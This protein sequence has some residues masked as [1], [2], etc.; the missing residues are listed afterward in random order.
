MIRFI[1]DIGNNFTFPIGIDSPEEV[2]KLLE[3]MKIDLIM[4]ELCNKSVEDVV[5]KLLDLK[6]VEQTDIL[7]I[8]AKLFNEASISNQKCQVKFGELT[9]KLIHVLP[10]LLTRNKFDS[11]KLKPREI[12]AGNFEREFWKVVKN[13]TPIMHDDVNKDRG[14]TT[15]MAHLYNIDMIQDDRLFLLLLMLTSQQKRHKYIKLLMKL[16]EPRVLQKISMHGARNQAAVQLHKF[17][18]ENNMLGDMKD[19]KGDH[20]EED[21]D[22]DFDASNSDDDSSAS[23]NDSDTEMPSTSKSIKKTKKSPKK[24]KKDRKSSDSSTTVDS[25]DIVRLFKDHLTNLQA[26]KQSNFDIQLF[27]SCNDDEK[28]QCAQNLLDAALKDTNGTKIYADIVLSIVQLSIPTRISKRNFNLFL[29]EAFEDKMKILSSQ[30]EGGNVD[31]DFLRGT[32]QF[33]AHLYVVDG[34]KISV[35]NNWLE[36]TKALAVDKEQALKILLDVHDIFHESMQ[37]RDV[38]AYRNFMGFLKDIHSKQPLPDSFLQVY[39][40]HLTEDFTDIKPVVKAVTKEKN[41]AGGTNAPVKQVPPQPTSSPYHTCKKFQEYLTAIISDPTISF[42]NYKMVDTSTEA[43]QGCASI[44]LDNCLIKMETTGIYCQSLT[45]EILPSLSSENQEKFKK[46]IKYCIYTEMATIANLEKY[47]ASN[48]LRAS[49]LTCCLCEFYKLY[50][51]DKDL[52]DAWLERLHLSDRGYYSESKREFDTALLFT[53]TFMGRKEKPKNLRDRTQRLKMKKSKYLDEMIIDTDATFKVNEMKKFT[54]IVLN[55]QN[56]TMDDVKTAFYS[57]E[58]ENDK[59]FKKFLDGFHELCLKCP[60]PSASAAIAKFLCIELKSFEFREKISDLICA[61]FRT[62]LLS[63]KNDWDDAENDVDRIVLVAAEFYNY[64]VISCLNYMNSLEK[65]AKNMTATKPIFIFHISLYSTALKLIHTGDGSDLQYIYQYIKSKPKSGQLAS[66]Y[67]Q[68]IDHYTAVFE[69]SSATVR[70]SQKKLTFAIILDNLNEI[71]FDNSVKYLEQLDVFNNKSNSGIFNKKVLSDM[72]KVNIYVR[73]ASEIS[74]FKYDFK[75]FLQGSLVVDFGNILNVPSGIDR[76]EKIKPLKE[77]DIPA[78][79]LIL[80]FVIEMYSQRF[81]NT[82]YIDLLL[83]FLSQDV[84]MNRLKC[85][86]YYLKFIGARIERERLCSLEECFQRIKQSLKSGHCKVLFDRIEKLSKN[87]WKFDCDEDER[88]YMLAMG[89]DWKYN[90][91]KVDADVQQSKTLKGKVQ[92]VGIK[93]EDKKIEK[94]NSG[95]SVENVGKGDHVQKGSTSSNVDQTASSSSIKDHKG[96]PNSN[97]DQKAPGPS[98]TPQNGT[99]STNIDH[100][101]SKSSS[102]PNLTLTKQFTSNSTQNEASTSCQSPGTSK[103]DPT[104]HLQSLNIKETKAMPSDNK[105]IKADNKPIQADTQLISKDSKASTADTKSMPGDTQP[106]PA[107]TELTPPSTQPTPSSIQPTPP[108]TQPT[109]SNTQPTPSSTQPTPPN[110]QPQTPAHLN[111]TY[112]FFT[113]TESDFEVFLNDLQTASTNL[114][115]MCQQAAQQV[116]K[117]ADSQNEFLQILWKYCLIDG[118]LV[119]EIAEICKKLTKNEEKFMKNLEKF[120][121]RRINSLLAIVKSANVK[122]HEGVRK[123]MANALLFIAALYSQDLITDSVFQSCAVSKLTSLLNCKEVADMLVIM[124]KKINEDCDE[125]VQLQAKILGLENL[126]E[127][128]FLEVFGSIK[129]DL[130]EIEGK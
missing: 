51:F 65:L 83:Q 128:K 105:S 109:T 92:D 90:T 14:M 5:S 48:W 96:P 117:S 97:N 25:A 20:D 112:E 52:V 123:R 85:V 38:N 11:S 101:G 74:K 72:T 22:S 24:V 28:Q 91:E 93:A 116:T 78:I 88:S 98:N 118:S 84:C 69:L 15:F 80:D 120:V 73:F 111:Q 66:R 33:L 31:W 122:E 103:A 7:N 64:G 124:T 114:L 75:D 113:K 55:I 126:Q 95:K 46:Y 57:I 10:T 41:K 4:R 6:L 106:T 13:R 36:H 45:S 26:N 49:N 3:R 59:D 42:Q 53:T 87:K 44:F 23:S 70:R 27:K 30:I 121:N 63:Y 34:L 16:I 18:K 108:S 115:T 9:K 21:D 119:T 86:G 62:T 82:A 127:R 40:K 35:F 58:I 68:F 100:K 12:I 94:E 54:S 76:S 107:D 129:N 47:E 77:E 37:K 39:G 99:M 125:N 71:N 79:Q 43:L 67:K 102:D 110:T 130:M 19:V 104:I 61:D 2:S 8:V 89:A 60:Y 29:K 32:G 1:D 17:M 56:Y 50:L 81:C